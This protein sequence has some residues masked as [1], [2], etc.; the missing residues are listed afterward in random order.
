M[1]ARES[2]LTEAAPESSAKTTSLMITG[3]GSTTSGIRPARDVVSCIK[4]AYAVLVVGK[5]SRRRV[6]FGLPA[7]EK[8]VARAHARGDYAELLLVKIVPAGDPE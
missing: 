8:A 5:A 7:A 6:L 2:R 4:D 1:K 3:H